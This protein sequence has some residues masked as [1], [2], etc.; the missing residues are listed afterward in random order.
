[1]MDATIVLTIVLMAVTTYL[2]RILG[3]L[4]LRNRVLSS[5]WQSVMQAA[6]GCVLIAVLA[7][8]FATGNPADLLALG[9]TL[10]AATRYSILPV[11]LIGVCTAALLRTLLPV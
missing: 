7:P 2:T 10:Y 9:I 4:A 5:E 6:P 1:M 8:K 11:V 3:F